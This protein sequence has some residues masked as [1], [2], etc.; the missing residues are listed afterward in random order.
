MKNRAGA[1]YT[2]IPPSWSPCRLAGQF[3]R[4]KSGGDPCSVLEKIVRQREFGKRF[5]RGASVQVL[6]H[7][8]DMGLKA[9]AVARLSFGIEHYAKMGKLVA[10]IIASARFVFQWIPVRKSVFSV[11][12]QGGYCGVCHGELRV[13]T[14]YGVQSNVCRLVPFG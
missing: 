14:E 13:E 3:G 8:P 4:D 11:R 6:A 5:E 10:S 1:V 2:S 12:E 9:V 7:I